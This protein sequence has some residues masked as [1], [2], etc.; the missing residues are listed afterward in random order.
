M[1]GIKFGEH[2]EIAEK[3]EGCNSSYKVRS[4]QDELFI[5]GLLIDDTPD[6]WGKE[7]DPKNKGCIGS[8][9]SLKEERG[10]QKLEC[11]KQK[12]KNRSE[13]S[14]EQQSADSDK[15]TNCQWYLTRRA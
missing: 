12:R 4:K 5:A 3:I 9:G 11:G 15:G 6:E 13:W 8:L 14:E 10:T 2:L 7:P 1:E